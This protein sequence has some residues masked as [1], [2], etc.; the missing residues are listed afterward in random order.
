[1]PVK[2]IAALLLSALILSLVGCISPQ[3]IT[4]DDQ[5]QAILNQSDRI[6]NAFVADRPATQTEIDTAVGY[7]TMSNIQTQVLLVG[8]GN[9]YG[10]AVEN[11]TGK[12]TFMTCTEIAGGPG[13]G[14]VNYRSLLLFHSQEAFDQF[15]AGDWLAHAETDAVAKAND[16]G[17]AAQTTSSLTR[18]ITI[19]HM[20]ES[21][22]GAKVNL[23]SLTFEPDPVLNP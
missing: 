4:T 3:G 20:T 5:R 15:I 21:G 11:A 22:F 14:V 18:N 17:G 2:P 23:S 9:G 10:V 6:V 19:R 8:A 13:V 1:M 16:T 12:Q 7:A